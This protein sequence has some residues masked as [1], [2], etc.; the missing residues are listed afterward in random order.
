[1]T[2]KQFFFKVV[3]PVLIP[4]LVTLVYVLVVREHMP[5]I[6]HFLKTYIKALE[7]DNTGFNN[8]IWVYLAVSISSVTT[9]YFIN[10]KK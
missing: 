3:V 5:E 8:F 2:N 10:R 9:A 4:G 6:T 1:M 7:N